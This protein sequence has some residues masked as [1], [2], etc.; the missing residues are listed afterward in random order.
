MIHYYHTLGLK[1]PATQQQIKKAF[2]KLAH[3]YHPDKPT[4]NAD[5]F[6]KI[7]EAYQMLTKNNN[8]VKNTHEHYQQPV[9]ASIFDDFDTAQATTK[10]GAKVIYDSNTNTFITIRW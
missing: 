2:H 5:K 1:Y 9:H 4:G 10:H 7:N 3:I 8:Y 6:K